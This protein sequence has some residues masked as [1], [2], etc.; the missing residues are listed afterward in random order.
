SSFIKK[1]LPVL[2]GIFNAQQ[3]ANANSTPSD[4]VISLFSRWIFPKYQSEFYVEFGFNDFSYNL[5]DFTTDQQHSAAYIIGIKKEIPLS[6]NRLIDFNGELTQTAQMPDYLVRNAGNWYEHGQVRQ[7]YTNQNQIMGAG[8]GKGNNVQTATITYI[9]GFKRLGIKLQRIQQDP[10][11]L[12]SGSYIDL[13]LRKTKW[14]D[15]ALGL[16]GQ[17]LAYR[18]LII[19]AE[20]QFVKSQNYGWVDHNDQF[21]FYGLLNLSYLW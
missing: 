21:N 13:F 6:R 11:A 5:R 15:Y 20:C 3:N 10:M 16:S 19:N 14:S 2:A 9:D 12:A 1:Y 8:S 7:G 18:K 17:L 4:Q